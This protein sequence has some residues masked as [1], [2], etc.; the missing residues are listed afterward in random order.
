MVV[1]PTIK[2]YLSYYTFEVK[3]GVNVTAVLA[4]SFLLPSI[5][6]NPPRRQ[7]CSA[8]G[9]KSTVVLIR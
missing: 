2:G 1:P 5:T 9:H 8:S 6:S 4:P 7:R 3:K